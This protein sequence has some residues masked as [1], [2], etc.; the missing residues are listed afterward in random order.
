[1]RLKEALRSLAQ[2][3]NLHNHSS[4]MALEWGL[5]EARARMLKRGVQQSNV[6]LCLQST[7]N[8]IYKRR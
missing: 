6:T 4:N 8:T 5:Y 2:A 3:S 7:K 1:M